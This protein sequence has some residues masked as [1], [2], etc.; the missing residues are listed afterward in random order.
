MRVAWRSRWRA[1]INASSASARG[2]G[3]SSSGAAGAAST[4]TAPNSSPRPA[5]VDQAG[6]I[7]QPR[8]GAVRPLRTIE[9]EHG[10]IED[11]SPQ[12]AG[13]RLRPVAHIGGL[14]EPLPGGEAEHAATQ[15]VDHVVG[16]AG[17]CALRTRDGGAIL[18]GIGGAGAGARGE[19]ELG[20]GAQRC[21][22]LGHV[23]H[24][25]SA[26]APTQSNDGLQ[27]IDRQPR[28]GARRQRTEV[29]ASGV[30]VADDR[31]ARPRCVDIETDVA[32]AIGAGAVAV[33]ARQQSTDEACFDDLRRQRIGQLDVAHRLRLAKEGADLASVVSPEV[34][35][36][37]LA[38]IGGFA[39]VEHLSTTIAEHV[40][41]RGPGERV[42]D[43]QLCRLGMA[44]ERRQGSE[45][46]EPCD[47]PSS[48]PFEEEVEQVGGGEGVIEGAMRRPVVEPQ[49]RGERG[50]AAVGHLVTNEA[51]SQRRG[52]DA[53]TSRGD[54]RSGATPRRGSRCRSRCCVPRSRSCR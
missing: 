23:P 49:A 3:T 45:V 29:H 27:C 42:G 37:A 2:S 48:R 34:A 25:Q 51:A 12:R 53:W 21:V 28:H 10:S 39:D 30:G 33:V 22:E 40:D 43:P 41:A 26:R 9:S 47:A 8:G 6:A 14:F 20:G 44:R 19:P 32:V 16:I 31:E 24:R 54:G 7:D 50:Q 38:E 36:H 11:L 35:A 17:E 5:D 52:V 15:F 46:I 4:P 18:A 1:R 13:E